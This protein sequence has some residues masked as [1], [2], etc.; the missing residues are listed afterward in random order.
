MRVDWYRGLRAGAKLGPIVLVV[1]IV[2][3]LIYTEMILGW[4]LGVE[5]EWTGLGDSILYLIGDLIIFMVVCIGIGVLFALI[6]PRLP[7]DSEPVRAIVL[8]VPLWSLFTLVTALVL[9]GSFD[10]TL[11]YY[12]WWVIVMMLSSIPYGYILGRLWDAEEPTE[13]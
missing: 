4:A 5:L 6:R 11:P 7:G 12:E 10:R 3:S 1:E 8:F 2:L 9:I 13:E